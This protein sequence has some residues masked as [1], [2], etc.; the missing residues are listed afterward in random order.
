MQHT[1]ILLVEDD[2]RLSQLIT[3]F[4]SSEGFQ[5]KSVDRGDLALIAV[6]QDPPELIILDMM[7]PGMDGLEVCQR[8][9][10][11]YDKPII[12]ITANDD[13]LTEISALNFGVDD[14]VAK[15]LR[16]HVLLARINALLRRTGKN[17]D[18]SENIIQVQD[19]VLDKGNRLVTWA[20][21]PLDLSDAESDVLNVLISIAGQLIS[22]EF[23]FKTVRGFEYDGSDRSIDMRISTLRKKLDDTRPPHRYIKSVRGKG[24]LFLSDKKPS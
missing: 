24:Y 9:R 14:F 17:T 1:K 3:T 10:P 16:P 22:R 11:Q 12:M 13:E 7:L 23:L 19:I 20:Q 15:P 2:P 4:L 5:I 8:I 18:S 21:Q 6:E